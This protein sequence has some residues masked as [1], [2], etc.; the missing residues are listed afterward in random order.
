MSD[1]EIIKEFIEVSIP[2]DHPA[3]YQYIMGRERSKVSAINQ[4]TKLA[5]GILTPPYTS[6][7][8]RTVARQFLK[9]KKK[10]YDIGLIE[11]RPIY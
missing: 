2:D 8:I 4:I 1:S 10:D 9:Q 3:I 7:H 11:I 6:G 5:D